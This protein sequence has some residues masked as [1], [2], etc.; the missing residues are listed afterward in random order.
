MAKTLGIIPARFASTRLP[1]KPLAKIG[2]ISMI[3][4]VYQQAIQAKL[5]A[6]WVATDDE[7]IQKEVES[8]GGKVVM[9][10]QNHTTGTSRAAEASSKI[11]EADVVV[12][13]QGD[14]PFIDPSTINALLGLFQQE[15]A[16]IGTLFTGFQAADEV[17]SPNRVKLVANKKGEVHYFSRSVIPFL[18]H[19]QVPQHL[20]MFKRHLGLYG[21]RA[22]I[23]QDIAKLPPSEWEKKEKLEQLTWLYNGYRIHAAEVRDSSLSID[24]PE[25]L[26]KAKDYL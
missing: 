2:G 7:R 17:L 18:P 5:N 25:D 1:G 23:L 9:T 24:T 11:G 3:Q 10:S 13:I 8:F 12:N 22:S 16:Q 4:R 21:Y 6:V 26:E 15:D 20:S 19:E 14:E